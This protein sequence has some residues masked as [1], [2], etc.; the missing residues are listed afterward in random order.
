[1]DWFSFHWTTKNCHWTSS[2]QVLDAI[3]L[4]Q[5]NLNP[6]PSLLSGIAMLEHVYNLLVSKVNGIV[7]RISFLIEQFRGEMFLTG[8]NENVFL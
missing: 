1:M 6:P 8:V 4:L 2:S 3:N 5:L 7:L